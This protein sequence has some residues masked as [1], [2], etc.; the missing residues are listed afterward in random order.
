MKTNDLEKLSRQL[1]L[2]AERVRALAQHL[3][4]V[5]TAL[6]ADTIA[7]VFDARK[8]NR[9]KSEEAQRLREVTFPV[10]ILNGTGSE[11]WTVLWESARR[12]SQ[13]HAYP[14]KVFPVAENGALC[15]LCQQD[16]DPAAGRRLQQFETFLASTAE[17]ELSRSFDL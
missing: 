7:T 3:K 6:S 13:E 15:V 8:E 4:V 9:R 10:G 16:L 11:L 12:F 5:E 17:R 14:A 1:A 2:R